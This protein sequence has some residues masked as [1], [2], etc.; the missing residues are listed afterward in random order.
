MN[1]KNLK[2]SILSMLVVSAMAN[3]AT[4]TNSIVKTT[5]GDIQGIISSDDSVNIYKGIP[6][7]K[8]PVGDLRWEATQA[9]EKWTGVLQANKFGPGCMQNVGVERL[10]WT[11][12]YLHSGEL[13][14]DCLYLNVWA[15]K[16]TESKKPVVVYIHGGGF[17]EGSGSVP[18]YDGVN[19]A[20]KGVVYV[21]LNYR[22][23]AFGFISSS[24]LQ[25]ENKTIANYGLLDQV[26]A[27]KWIKE[28]IANF[29]GDENNIT[30]M[31][32]S[33]GANSVLYLNATSLTKGLFN[34]SVIES[35]VPSF[36]TMF[37]VKTESLFSSPFTATTLAAQTTQV[38]DYLK[39]NGLSI[40][41]LKTM[42]AVDVFKAFDPQKVYF[43]PVIGGNVND[44]PLLESFSVVNSESRPIML[45]VNKDEL[46]GFFDE[47]RNGTEEQ[48]KTY[49]KQN[50]PSNTAEIL[51]LYPGNARKALNGDEAIVATHNLSKLLNKYTNAPVYTYFFKHESKASAH[52]EYGAFHT[53]EVPY[54]TANLDKLHYKPTKADLA[55]ESKMSTNLINFATYGTPDSGEKSWADV[56]N[57]KWLYVVDKKMH[58]SEGVSDNNQ[59]EISRIGQK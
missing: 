12:E 19:L 31:G 5:K 11:K 17:V 20:K 28:N 25:A 3:A 33:A 2:V 53:S 45:G 8:A 6:Y 41:K 43:G 18:I 21:S 13:S 32:Q 44:K 22:L 54:I 14:E 38:D 7:A 35:P 49:V 56:S 51:K 52:P 1:I 59:N 36:F 9:N 30:I 27:L 40:K 15:P 55:I 10:P 4:A 16:N 23:G 26:M 24:E 48:Y 34:R 58:M 57:E 29:G 37:G 39:K 50:Y 46:S 47:Y 42:N